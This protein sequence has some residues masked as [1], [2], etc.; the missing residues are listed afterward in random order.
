MAPADIFIL[1]LL[2][3]SIIL[4]WIARRSS[5]DSSKE[6]STSHDH[7]GTGSADHIENPDGKHDQ[8]DHG[9]TKTG[10]LNSRD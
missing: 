3:G 7:E 5:S 6:V 10:E 1:I 2:L 8:I 4:I 9:E